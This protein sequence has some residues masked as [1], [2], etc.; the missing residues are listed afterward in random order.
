MAC[1]ADHPGGGL[2]EVW[3]LSL[4]E[5]K[6]DIRKYF[7]EELEKIRQDCCPFCLPS[8]WPSKSY[9]DKLVNKSEGLFVW[10]GYPQM[11][12]E[13]VVKVHDGLDPLYSQVIREAKG[14]RYFGIVMGALMHLGYLLPIDKFS[15][16]L[17]DFDKPLEVHDVLFA[18]G[19]CHSILAIPEDH[20]K[21]IEPY[22]A[23]L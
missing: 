6:D 11:L 10:K 13:D 3:A 19:G 5:S 8:D 14:R 9:I 7:I 20:T 18:L 17:F 21:A 4:T 23:S 15:Q 22:H 2:L 1:F 12:L 16:V